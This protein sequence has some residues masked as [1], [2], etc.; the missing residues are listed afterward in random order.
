MSSKAGRKKSIVPL[1]LQVPLAVV[2]AVVFIFLLNARLRGGR[3][4]SG[5]R[6]PAVQDKVA[7]ADATVADCEQRLGV[8]ME[9]ITARKPR[10]QLHAEPPPDLAGDPFVKPHRAAVGDRIDEHDPQRAEP[11]ER[12]QSREAFIES[13]TLQATLVDGDANLA[14]IN[15][16]LLTENDTMGPFSVVKIEERTAL[17]SDVTGTVLLTMKGDD[18][19]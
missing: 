5:V 14:L 18:T 4:D 6:V 7:C 11:K 19:P 9:K 15:G 12:R 17:L 8:L 1:K 2:L 16:T 13:L 10:G 3:H